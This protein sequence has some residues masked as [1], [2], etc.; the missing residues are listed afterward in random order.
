ML[1]DEIGDLPAHVQV[2]LLRFLDRYESR[3]VGEHRVR[4]VDVRILA[5][6]HKNLQQMVEDGGFREDLFYRLKVFQ[7]DVPALRQRREDIPS[8][9]Q[10]FLQ[11][12]WKS[13]LP[14][15]ISPDLMLWMDRY[16]WPGNVREL[17]NLCRYLSARC[18]GKPEVGVQDLP[19][20]LQRACHDL[21][22]GTE[23]SMFEREKHELE[24]TQILRALQQSSGNISEA[25]RLLGLGRNYV[26]R[27][28]RDYRIEREM[29]KSGGTGAI[30]V[31][32]GRSSSRGSYPS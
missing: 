24:R 27:K 8:L 3:R 1:L 23:T 22:G 25:S 7:V 2:K 32:S 19:Q 15:Q 4:T 20:D 28:I 10:Q 26:A 18:W 17:R 29:F 31:R 9:A 13:S 16:N 12:D 5:A 6:T 14:I 30:E 21:L 11:E